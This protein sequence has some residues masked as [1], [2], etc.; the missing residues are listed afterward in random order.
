MPPTCASWLARA[1]T[2]RQR[3]ASRTAPRLYR[4]PACTARAS[5]YV[6]RPADPR[7][8]GYSKDL[9]GLGRPRGHRRLGHRPRPTV[10]VA[11]AGPGARPARDR[12]RRRS[13][14]DPRCHR[15]GGQAA[16][17]GCRAVTPLRRARQVRRL[18]IIVA[19]A[20]FEIGSLLELDGEWQQLE[21]IRI[22]MGDET[23]HRTKKA[24]LEAAKARAA[25]ALE[26]N[27]E[28]GKEKNPFLHGAPAVV[29][30]LKSGR[31]E[32][33]VATSV[34]PVPSLASHRTMQ[35]ASREPPVRVEVQ[36][37]EELIHRHVGRRSPWA[38]GRAG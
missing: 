38:A 34:K 5:L 6:S 12:H 25:A 18:R 3:A 30:A 8:P 11:E 20:F 33:R 32:C 31:I 29:E 1:C 22:P 24:F 37:L 7:G 14:G 4:A 10:Q 27:L 13:R 9:E 16:L 21:K 36:R 2:R 23:T 17:G 15:A 26:R 19:T 28:E 35:L